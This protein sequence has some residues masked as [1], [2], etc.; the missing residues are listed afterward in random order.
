MTA[1][2]SYFIEDSASL[3]FGRTTERFHFFLKF[4]QLFYWNRFFKKTALTVQFFLMWP[5]LFKANSVEFFS[6]FFYQWTESL[7]IWVFIPL[8]YPPPRLVILKTIKLFCWNGSVLDC[9]W[10]AFAMFFPWGKDYFKCPWK[11]DFA[12]Q[13]TSNLHIWREMSSEGF[14]DLI[15]ENHN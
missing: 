6:K 10:K 8:I 1:L 14:K 2:I 7:S 4:F 12:L 11:A 13:K 9:D 5:L 3:Q 15:L